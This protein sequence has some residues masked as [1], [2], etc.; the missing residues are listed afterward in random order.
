V[1]CIVRA[2]QVLDR[3]SNLVNVGAKWMGITT[4]AIMMFLITADVIMRTSVGKPILGAY[5]LTQF[6]M[7]ILIFFALPCTAFK[8]GHV[9]V[10]FIY[11]RLSQRGR[12]VIDSIANFLSLALFA[13]ICWQ[14]VVQGRFLLHSKQVSLALGIPIYGFLFVVAVGC[15]LLCLVLLSKLAQS[16]SKG[17]KK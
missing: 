2:G 13:L 10:D 4:L 3:I 15:T 5:E 7:V 6:L 12:A 8:D 14:S 17:S 9:T 16:L 11:E 1:G